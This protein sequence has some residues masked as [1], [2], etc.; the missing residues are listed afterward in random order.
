MDVVSPITDVSPSPSAS[1]K[2]GFRGPRTPIP[3]PG[4]APGDHGGDTPVL[5]V[6]PDLTIRSITPAAC[7]LFGIHESD[8]GRSLADV[9]L[10]TRDPWLFDD[11]RSVMTAQGAVEREVRRDG[12]WRLR[13]SAPRRGRPGVCEGVVITSVALGARERAGVAFRTALGGLDRAVGPE[14]VADAAID[15]IR[16]FARADKR[17][18]SGLVLDALERALLQGRGPPP[19]LP[20][21]R[22][23]ALR[24]ATLSAR[25]REVMDS[26]VEGVASKVIA[27][28]LGI[29]QRTVENHRAA[30][31]RKLGVRSIAALARVACRAR[32]EA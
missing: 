8:I 7:A 30:M 27:Y 2:A 24:I 22:E 14:I 15:A 18:L 31:M 23:A 4:D 28:E 1:R 13:R 9:A 16:S 10:S 32:Q 11:S 6:A 21:D 25:Q 5:V 20:F 3:S 26:V 12:G 19:P 17:V 29:S